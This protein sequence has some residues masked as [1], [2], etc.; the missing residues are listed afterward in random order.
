[1]PNIPNQPIIQEPLFNK[2]RCSN[3][4]K[5]KAYF[6][7][8]IGKKIFTTILRYRGSRDGWKGADFHRLCD[9]KGPTV[10]LFNI[11]EN[12]HCVGGFTSA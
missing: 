5:E 3:N 12:G 2:S 1:M 11:L 10:A 9:R 7:E 6:K 8:I 4:P